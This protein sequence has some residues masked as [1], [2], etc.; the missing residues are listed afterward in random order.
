MVDAPKRFIAIGAISSS[1]AYDFT[2][3]QMSLLD[4][5]ALAGG[6]NDSLADRRG[7]YL[8]R[9]VPQALD[10][11]KLF[12]LDMSEPYSPF[13]ASAF[14]VRPGDAIYV[15]NALVTDFDKIIAPLV[16]SISTLRSLTTGFPL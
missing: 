11:G 1:G 8:F 14:D 5:L 16:R 7:V 10:R 4:A 12:L 9:P 13:V 6:L 3:P 2:A 15:T